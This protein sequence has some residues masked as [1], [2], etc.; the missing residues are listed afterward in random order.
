R[1]AIS[2]DPCLILRV[3]AATV[4]TGNQ[5]KNGVWQR[6]RAEPDLPKRWPR[7]S[8]DDFFTVLTRPQV[9]IEID[10]YGLWERYVPEW[11]YIR[12]V[13][14]RERNH[15]HT[16]DFHS[17]ETVERCAQVRTTVGRPDLLLLGAL[18]HEIGRAHV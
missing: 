9:I 16:I 5:V 3:D 1:K 17:V 4:L 8:A 6:L 14:P 10:K 15:S 18:F 7:T 11:N 2:N 12:G 13:L